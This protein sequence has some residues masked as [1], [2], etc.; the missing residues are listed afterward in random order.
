MVGALALAACGGEKAAAPESAEK[1]GAA[2]PQAV[3]APKDEA[4]GGG[5]MAG[6]ATVSAKGAEDPKV[7]IL[8]SSEFQ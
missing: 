7:V 8:E 3:E 5:D 1:E 2:T 6:L 4:K